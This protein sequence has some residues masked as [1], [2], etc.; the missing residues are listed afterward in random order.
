MFLLPES[1]FRCSFS[2]V[3]FRRSS[4][5]SSSAATTNAGRGCG[6]GN[7]GSAGAPVVCGVARLTLNVYEVSA[8]RPVTLQLSVPELRPCIASHFQDP[9]AHRRIVRGG[10]P[11]QGQAG[12]GDFEAVRALPSGQDGAVVIS[13][14]AA[15]MVGTDWSRFYHSRRQ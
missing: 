14:V 5:A 4:A 1:F 3:P 15:V 13:G 9:V 2:G 10:C 12:P 7:A 11:G 8:E 6:H